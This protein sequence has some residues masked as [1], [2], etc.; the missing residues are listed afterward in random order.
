MVP[1][2]NNIAKMAISEA[3][4]SLG[5]F[6]KNSVHSFD[7]IA[8]YETLLSWFCI[9]CIKDAFPSAPNNHKLQL[10]LFLLQNPDVVKEIIE[11]CCANISTLTIDLLHKHMHNHIIPFYTGIWV[12]SCLAQPYHT[13]F[14]RYLDITLPCTTIA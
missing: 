10:P 5:V 7:A 8:N 12:L 1:D 4:T 14:Y 6:K 13:S 2:F 3:N 11:F 9:Y